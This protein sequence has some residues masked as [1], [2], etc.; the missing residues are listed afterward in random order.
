LKAKP[1]AFCLVPHG[2]RKK[3]FPGPSGGTYS[4]GSHDPEAPPDTENFFSGFVTLEIFMIR[5]IYGEN[6][7]SSDKKENGSRES[8][9]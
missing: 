6:K 4:E 3:K 5:G 1:R 2:C 8:G 7:V 9:E